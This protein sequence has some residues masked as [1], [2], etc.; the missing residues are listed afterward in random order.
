MPEPAVSVLA[1]LLVTVGA[2]PVFIA[3][4]K[5]I[6]AVFVRPAS[7]SVISVSLMTTLLTVGGVV[8]SVVP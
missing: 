4:E 6:V 2:T 1:A 8:S 3:S 7:V 5:V